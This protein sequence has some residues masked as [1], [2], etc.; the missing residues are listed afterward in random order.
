MTDQTAAALRTLSSTPASTRPLLTLRRP[1]RW[2]AA[3]LVFVM[4]AGPA[5]AV[6]THALAETVGD[7][8]GAM[9]MSG[10]RSHAPELGVP[11]CHGQPEAPGVPEEAPAPHD[12]PRPCASACCAS[13]ASLPDE[14]ALTPHLASAAVPAP[15]ESVVEAPAEAPAP[16]PVATPPPPRLRVHLALQRLVI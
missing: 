8:H 2:I 1:F 5:G 14:Q 7:A 13:P 4:T 3:A 6:C 10:E 9:E 16:L 11:P 15:A 12:V